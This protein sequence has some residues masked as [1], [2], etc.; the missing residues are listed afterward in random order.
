[1]K[2]DNVIR[3]HVLNPRTDRKHD[4]RPFMAEQV[5]KKSVFT[6]NPINLTQLR[7]TNTAVSNL[8]QHLPDTK[9]LGKFHMVD[10]QRAT[11]FRKDCGLGGCW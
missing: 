2:D 11:L 7:T 6:L 9:F 4:P 1:V 5:G 8:D 10:H 3:C